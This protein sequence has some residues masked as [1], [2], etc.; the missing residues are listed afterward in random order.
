MDFIQKRKIHCLVTAAIE[1]YKKTGDVKNN[2]C[3]SQFS[4]IKD[5][6]TLNFYINHEYA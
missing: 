5:T 4:L 3:D 1:A 2:I 6:D